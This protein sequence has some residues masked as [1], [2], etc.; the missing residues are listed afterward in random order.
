[1]SKNEHKRTVSDIQMSVSSMIRTKDTK[2]LYVM[3]HDEKRNAEFCL[4]ECKL[5]R[6][7]GFSD[8]EISKLV[9]YVKNEQDT[10]YG[11]A[12]KVNPMKAFLGTDD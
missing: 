11:L 3:F 5:V 8:E 10:I 6:N 2:V 12:K 9:D 7:N 4:P 1:M